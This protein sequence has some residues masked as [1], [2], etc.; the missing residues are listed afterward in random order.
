LPLSFLHESVNQFHIRHGDGRGNIVSEVHYKSYTDVLM[1]ISMNKAMVILMALL[2]IYFR[3][4]AGLQY[5][6]RP[7][8]LKLDIA[9]A[10]IALVSMP[11]I[12]S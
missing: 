7:G 6:A 10:A 12:T 2:V 9:A 1:E 3:G 4:E 11:C 5:L 8:D